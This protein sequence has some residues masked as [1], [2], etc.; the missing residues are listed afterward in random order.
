MTQLNK[1]ECKSIKEIADSIGVSKQAVF[2]RIKKEPLSTS[3][4]GLMDKVDGR[5][6]VTVDG[7][8]LIKQ[9]FFDNAFQPVDD[10]PTTVDD[11]QFTDKLSETE[12]VLSVLKATIDSLQVQLQVKDEQI[13][14]LTSALDAEREHSRV[15]SDKVVVLADQ[16]QKLQLAQMQPKLIE[17]S[18]IPKEQEERKHWWMIFGRGK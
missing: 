5:L 16:A 11:N 3:L 6:M 15:L 8:K 10:K 9:A 2:K 13:E 18:E 7:E 12:S 17:D 4:Q 14:K 1:E